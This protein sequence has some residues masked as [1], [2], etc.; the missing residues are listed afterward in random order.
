MVLEVAVI[1]SVKLA[2]KRDEWGSQCCMVRW[3][4]YDY[5]EECSSGGR[6]NSS[7]Y[8]RHE[9]NPRRDTA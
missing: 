9:N 4:M 1:M 5:A 8:T 6:L 3:N 7:L 2:N